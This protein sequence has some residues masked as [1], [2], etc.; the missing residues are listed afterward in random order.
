MNEEQKIEMIKGMKDVVDFA[1]S[2]AQA[3]RAYYEALVNSGF[4]E[5][6]ALTLI[7]HHGYMPPTHMKGDSK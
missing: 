3:V 7:C 1:I 2:H 4:S 5:P 6:E